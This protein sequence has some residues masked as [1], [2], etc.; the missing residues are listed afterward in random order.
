[1]RRYLEF[2]DTL[3][4]ITKDVSK[5]FEEPITLLEEREN[6]Y[7]VIGAVRKEFYTYRVVRHYDRWCLKYIGY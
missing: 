7:R 4:E 6:V 3:E 5:H 2:A 1:M